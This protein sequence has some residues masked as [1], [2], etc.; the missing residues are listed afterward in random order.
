MKTLKTVHFIRRR[1]HQ[2]TDK[3]LGHAMS[4]FHQPSICIIMPS[5]LF[6]RKHVNKCCRCRCC[7]WRGCRGR[8][9]MLMWRH[10]ALSRTSC[11]QCRNAK[12]LRQR[13]MT[14]AAAVRCTL[15][16]SPSFAHARRKATVDRGHP[17]HT[18]CRRWLRR[19]CS[20]S[21]SSCCSKRCDG[22]MRSS[23]CGCRPSARTGQRP[24]MGQAAAA[25][26]TRDMLC[27]VKSSNCS[28]GEG[29]SCC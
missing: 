7:G 20:C 25:L 11:S 22:A 13:L 6:A 5:L 24:K 2:G 8:G 27:R 14:R 9:L 10:D 23:A 1:L 17:Q 28:N 16:L 18:S 3:T 12:L 21:D 19:H 15:K 4:D 26:S 29:S